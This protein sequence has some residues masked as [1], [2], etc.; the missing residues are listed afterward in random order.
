MKDVACILP[1][2]FFNWHLS[3]LVNINHAYYD[4]NNTYVQ[5]N[6]LFIPI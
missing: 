1:F 3:T 5:G 4:I 2:Q 6:A